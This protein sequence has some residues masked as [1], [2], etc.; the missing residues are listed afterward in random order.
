ML[1][2]TEILRDRRQGGEPIIAHCISNSQVSQMF[3]HADK[4]GMQTRIQMQCT[5]SVDEM[6]ICNSVILPHSQHKSYNYYD[7]SYHHNYIALLQTVLL[8]SSVAEKIQCLCR[9]VTV[10][11]S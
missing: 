10:Q 6:T 2:N 4:T 9:S 5:K 1:R 3:S 11:C 8:L 7:G